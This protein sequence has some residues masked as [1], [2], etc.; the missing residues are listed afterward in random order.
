MLG[1]TVAELRAEGLLPASGDGGTLPLD[2]PIAVKEAVLPFGRFRDAR[3]RGRGHRARPGDALDRRGDGHRRGVRHRVRQV[4][5]GRV[6]LAAGQ[7]PRVRLG[8]QQ[9][10]ARRWCSR[11]S[12]W[13]TWA[14]RSGPPAGTGEVLRRNGVRATIV[15][16]HSDGPGPD[17]EPTIVERILAGQVD[18]IVN[19]PFGSPGQSG[20]RL[21]GY[22]IRTAAVRR[23]IPCVTTTAGPGRG[24]AGHRGHQLRRG[25]RA[26]AAGARG[27][28]AGAAGRAGR[29]DGTATP[30]RRPARVQVRGTVLT[31]RRVDAY[32]AMTVVAPGIAA[33]F[34]PGQFVD[35]GR[36]RPGHVDAAAPGVLDPRRAP[37]PRRH[38]GVRVRGGR[39]GDPVAG[40][41]PLP[42]RRSTSPG[43]SGGRSRCPGT[44]SPACSSAAATAARRCSRWP[45]GCASAGCTV[46]FLLGAAS[47]DRVFGALTARRTGRTATITTEDGSLG[48][49]GIVTDMLGQV[50]HEART[51]VIYACGPMP[52]LRQVT[53]LARRYDIPVQVA[54]EEPMACGIGVCMTCVLPV[55]GERRDHPDGPVLRGR[56]GVPRRAGALGRRG[57][58]PVRR[59]RRARAGSRG[60]AA[61][62]GCPAARRRPAGRRRRKPGRWR[63]TCGPGS[64]RSSC[65]TRS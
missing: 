15:R 16:K 17:G 45:T 18:L 42:G 11:S 33:R 51:D 38:G 12:A 58:D 3:R 35:P 40:R 56:P 2:A 64:A 6:R 53:A 61:R 21:D 46:D 27:A 29:H 48:A 26:V 60:R 37:G 52:M 25:G 34:R 59:A 24:R 28:P 13:P 47:G 65:R 39:A 19:T 1:A 55:I 20:P 50:I 54:V 62:P 49:R 57:H 41:A 63:L 23:G 22:E 4:P 8:G 7:G 9:G 30:R 32:Y 44:R 14:S 10:Q 43:R 36:R 5:G 31:V